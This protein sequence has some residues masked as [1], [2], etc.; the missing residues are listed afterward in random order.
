MS[1]LTIVADR[2]PDY[3]SEAMFK[4]G[5][6]SNATSTRLNVPAVPNERG[7]M[8]YFTKRATISAALCASFLLAAPMV[9]AQSFLCP[10]GSYV[11]SGPCTL[12]PDGSYVG[13]G[14]Q[15]ALTPG[16]GYVP[17]GSSPPQLAPDGTWHPGGGNV[18]LCPD[19]TYVTG[20]R[21]VLTPSGRYVGG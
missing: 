18:I 11:S 1:P 19:G 9:F 5:Q 3:V 6:D 10:N 7:K 14:A 16:G 20:S 8:L 12:C 13:G 15:C 2:T 4:R 17:G 21:C